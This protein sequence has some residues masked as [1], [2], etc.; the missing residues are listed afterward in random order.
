MAFCIKWQFF[1]SLLLFIMSFLAFF[2]GGYYYSTHF[3]IALTLIPLGC[4]LF[5]CGLALCLHTI[6]GYEKPKTI[7]NENSLKRVRFSSL[8]QVYEDNSQSFSDDGNQVLLE[9]NEQENKHADVTVNNR[10]N[11]KN[12]NIVPSVISEQECEMDVLALSKSDGLFKELEYLLQSDSELTIKDKKISSDWDVME[13][14]YS[15][16]TSNKINDSVQHQ[17]EASALTF[18]E[19]DEFE[20]IQETVF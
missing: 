4:V 17:T 15:I 18:E 12:S 3:K 14:N 1:V 11:T 8:L 5:S 20:D 6:L 7:Q 2:G 9:E 19:N 13:F 10:A 16:V